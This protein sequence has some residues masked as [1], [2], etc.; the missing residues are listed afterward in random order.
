MVRRRIRTPR[1]RCGAVANS[2][3]CQVP[4][5]PSR[6]YCSSGLL[7]RGRTDCREQ[8]LRQLPRIGADRPHA[9]Y[10][11]ARSRER[12]I[13]G[14]A[15]R[16]RP[17]ATHPG[18]VAGIVGAM[19]CGALAPAIRGR[20]TT[21]WPL[22]A[23]LG[24][25]DVVV[26]AMSWSPLAGLVVCP[27]AGAMIGAIFSARFVAVGASRTDRARQRDPELGHER[28]PRRLRHRD[29][30]RRVDRLRTGPTRS[31]CR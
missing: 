13:I 30:L 7:E 22:A 27:R 29:I 15:R 21:P 24:G 2:W 31:P 28:R 3:P 16:R 25:T 9:H 8:G 18:G 23:F 1:E 12:W 20:I 11:I 26:T 17:M 4:A 5:G 14:R 10:R 6:S 19:G